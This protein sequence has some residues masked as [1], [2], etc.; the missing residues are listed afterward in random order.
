MSK[1]GAVGGKEKPKITYLLWGIAVAGGVKVVFEHVNRLSERGYNVKLVA[2]FGEQPTWFKLK[3]KIIFLPPF[4]K[5]EDFPESDIVVATFWPTAYEVKNLNVKHK[6]YLV[7]HYEPIFSTDPIYSE[8]AKNTYRLSLTHLVVSHWIAEMLKKEVNQPSIYI[9]NGIDTKILYFRPELRKPDS[10][11]RKKN[12]LIVLRDMSYWK[13]SREA[14]EVCKELKSRR[15]D[16]Y[17]TLVSGS[18]EILPELKKVV[19]RNI[20]RMLSQEELVEIYHKADIFIS[21]SWLEG[22]G[23]P[24]LEAMAC[25]AAV[26]TTDSGGVRDFC[27]DGYNCFVVPPKKP[28]L[29]V[30]KVL[31]LLDNDELRRKFSENGIKTASEFSWDRVIDRLEE[32]FLSTAK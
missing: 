18:K 27:R 20:Y 2:H 8:L 29:M 3:K 30:D 10:K 19:D 16:I 4:P 7:Q 11:K 6:F 21:T 23:L 1:V 26:V 22:F 13:G 31:Q 25:G 14:I 24:P 32:I 17:I 28:K 12:I 15:K 9:S 5:D